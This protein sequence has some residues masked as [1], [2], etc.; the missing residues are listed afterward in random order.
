MANERYT[1]T[2]QKLHFASLALERWQHALAQGDS[3]QQAAERETS[4]LHLYGALLGLCHEVGGFYRVA[5]A[6]ASSVEA[7]LK[8]PLLQAAPIPEL[9]ELLELAEHPDT[10]L[11]LLLRGHAALFLPL[12]PAPKVRQDVTQPLIEAVTLEPASDEL[13]LEDV[14]DWRQQLRELVLR[15]REGMNEC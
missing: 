9:A 15:F 11:A 13:S 12:R 3:T 14:Q 8:R 1:R 5:G 6:E 7:I 4:L 2:N 10:W